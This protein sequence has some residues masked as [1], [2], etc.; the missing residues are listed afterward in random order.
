MNREQT[1]MRALESLTPGGSEFVGDINRCVEHVR[2]SRAVQIRIMRDWV[3]RRQE[4]D[5]AV[6]ALLN[7]VRPHVFSDPR[8]LEAYKR[9]AELF[10]MKEAA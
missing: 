4:Q 6:K 2:H 7:A 10:N 1:A 5:I 3:K 9:V 8:M